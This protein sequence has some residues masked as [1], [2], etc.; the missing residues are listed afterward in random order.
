MAQGL[1]PNSIN[2]THE[3]YLQWV[4]A[5]ALL[6]LLLLHCNFQLAADANL[7]ESKCFP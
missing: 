3:L 4:R 1:P 6:L 5:P 2:V 7:S